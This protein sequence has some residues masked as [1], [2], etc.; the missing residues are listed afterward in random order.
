ME[1]IREAFGVERKK[2]RRGVYMKKTVWRFHGNQVHIKC[3]GCGAE[4]PL[5]WLEIRQDAGP[6]GEA[7]IADATSEPP[8]RRRRVVVLKPERAG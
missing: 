3:A 8:A 5:N 6:P 4:F 1:H 2:E 7:E